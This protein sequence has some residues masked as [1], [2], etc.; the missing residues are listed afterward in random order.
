[1]D[2]IVQAT[3]RG[4]GSNLSS[5][6]E[7]GTRGMAEKYNNGFLHIT[8]GDCA[9]LFSLP[10][11]GVSS[12]SN[13]YSPSYLAEVSIG[14]NYQ[15]DEAQAMFKISTLLFYLDLVDDGEIVTM[16]FLGGEDDACA[17]K[18]N[19]MSS[20]TATIHLP[21][22]EAIYEQVDMSIMGKYDEEN[23]YGS[24]GQTLDTVVMM[25]VSQLQKIIDVVEA[26][27]ISVKKFY[28]ITVQDE[29]LIMD[30]GDSKTRNRVYGPLR[31]ESV[32][33][34]DCQNVYGTDFPYG[35]NTLSGTIMVNT[36]PG[37][38]GAPISLVQQGDGFVI[39]HVMAPSIASM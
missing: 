35:V 2:E 9:V 5:M 22:S 7:R 4:T 34:P 27:E 39:R 36:G 20:L 33:G 21:V 23:I 24:G 29:E 17:S 13:F 31:T 12:Y 26:D 38:R 30:V 11:G 37:V 8:D 32:T 6:I 19:I 25:D 1:M 16:E 18:V 14:K 3:I 28:P 15:R 10:G